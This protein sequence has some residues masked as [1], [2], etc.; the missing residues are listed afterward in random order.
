ML[1]E[2]ELFIKQVVG[3]TY[4]NVAY[5]YPYMFANGNRRIYQPKRIQNRLLKIYKILKNVSNQ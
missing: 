3:L 2:I 4:N 1:K 5:T